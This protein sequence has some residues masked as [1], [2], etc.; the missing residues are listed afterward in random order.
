MGSAVEELIEQ[1]RRQMERLHNSAV[2]RIIEDRTRREFDRLNSPA[3]RAMEE[4]VRRMND[5]MFWLMQRASE[6]AAI[7]RKER[8]FWFYRRTTGIFSGDQIR[9]AVNKIVE[10]LFP[11][12]FDPES[13]TRRVRA[14]LSKQDSCKG[15]VKVHSPPVRLIPQ[16]LHPIDSVA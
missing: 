4:H 9:K 11:K 8:G 3:Y 6:D 10:R 2:G 16:T 13:F 5:P 14:A 15:I 7:R 1:N 12:K